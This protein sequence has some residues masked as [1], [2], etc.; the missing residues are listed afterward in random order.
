[1][2]LFRSTLLTAGIL[3]R[4]FSAGSTEGPVSALRSLLPLDVQQ[5]FENVNRRQVAISRLCELSPD[6]TVERCG[7]QVDT[8]YLPLYFYFRELLRRHRDSGKSSPLFIG[9]SAPQGC[10]KTTLTTLIEELFEQDGSVCVSCSI[11]DFYLTGAA[12]DELAATNP[13]NPLLQYRGN[14]GTHDLALL[15]DT[16][17]RLRGSV[18]GAVRVPRYDKSLRG[19]RGDRAPEES[20]RELR[21]G[22]AADIVLFE[23][24]MLGFEPLPAPAVPPE[25][26]QVNELLRR[27]EPVHA[28][29]DAWLVLAVESTD[30]VYRWR[31]Q[32]EQN[33]GRQNKP[34]LS[35]DQVKD[36]VDRFMP[37]YRAY[38]PGLYERGPAGRGGV[39]S[40]TNQVNSDGTA[41]S[42]HQL[43][44]HSKKKSA[45]KIL[46]GPDRNLLGAELIP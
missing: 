27:Y 26:A 20:W 28:A 35:D 14:A 4:R 46:L 36:F 5:E 40:G 25:L 45:L 13:T 16:L 2:R 10:G 30:Y 44:G 43:Q 22:S 24:W 37:A 7:R 8:F 42:S 12:Q 39:E 17:D 15:S 34:R 21:V 33:M 32:A 6:S 23:G 31:L 11:D 18:T 3:L 9:V 1:M 41:V 38:L 29:M 19:G